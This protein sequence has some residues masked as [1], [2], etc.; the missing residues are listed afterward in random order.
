M[1][2]TNTP[3]SISDDESIPAA[4]ANPGFI[5][6]VKCLP[7]QFSTGS[8]GWKGNKRVTMEVKNEAGEMEKVQVQVTINATVL[9]SKNALDTACHRHLPRSPLICRVNRLGSRNHDR[10]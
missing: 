5:S 7:S 10:L 1:N 2:I 8:Y 6:D 4:P 9:G 3:P